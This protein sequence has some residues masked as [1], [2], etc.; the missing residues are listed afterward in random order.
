MKN[1]SILVGVLSL[2]TF[3]MGT[4][5][6]FAAIKPVVT[7]TI[8]ATCGDKKMDSKT[9]GKTTDAKCGDKKT[10]VKTKD[11]KCGEGKC[12]GKKMKKNN[13]AS[14]AKNMAGKETAKA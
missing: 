8:E 5:T 1:K 14:K 4:A 6:T 2:G 10:E 7:T 11:G 12:G 13:K 3:A 9:T